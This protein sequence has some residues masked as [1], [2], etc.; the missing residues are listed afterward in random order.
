MLKSNLYLRCYN[1]RRFK[2]M[3]TGSLWKGILL[4]SL[5]LFVSNLLQILFNMT[6][7]AV[8]GKFSSPEALDAVGSITILV[9]LFTGFLIGLGNGI[10]VLIA[11]YLGQRNSKNVHDALHTSFVLSVIMGIILFLLGFFFLTLGREFLQT[12]NK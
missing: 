1:G 12:R 6:D 3:L 8:I 5:P 9:T 11:R 2:K 10:N 7:V 4:F